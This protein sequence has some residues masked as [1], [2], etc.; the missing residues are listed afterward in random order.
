MG[1]KIGVKK[2]VEVEAKTI[3]FTAKCSDCFGGEIRDQ[4]GERIGKDH[5]GY[6]PRF[7]PEGGGDY[8]AFDIDLA[9]GQILNWTPPTKE[10]IEEFMNAED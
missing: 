6:V 5:D 7:F 9:T 4:H 1:I 8:I 3:S 10:Q 2:A